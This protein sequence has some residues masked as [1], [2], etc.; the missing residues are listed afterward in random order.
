MAAMKRSA[1][2]LTSLLILSSSSPTP[3]TAQ[4]LALRPQVFAS[5]FSSPV[6]F[7]QDPANRAVQFVVEQGGRIRVVRD[8]VVLPNDFLDL[9]SAI[10]SGGE[11]GLLGMA[12]PADSSGRVFVNFTNPAGHT[13]VARFRRSADPLV[14]D[15]ASRFD[16]RWGGGSAFIVQP[17][18]NH[19][20]G[21]MVF[22]PDGSLYI[23][24]GDGG[25][26][27]DPDH[28]AQNLAELLGKMLR[29]DVSVPDGHPNGYQIP[30]DNPFAAG[31]GRPEIWSVGLRNPWR[32][33]FD[34]P[35]RGGTGAMVLGDV[36]Q[37]RFEE[38]DYEP[39]GRGGRNYGW[40]NREGA[41]DNVTSRP[42]AFTPLVDPVHEYS[43][44]DGQ[45]ITGGFVYRGRLLGAGFVGRYFFAD[46]VQ[47]RVWSIA[48]SPDG[49]SGEA[50]AAGLIEHTADLSAGTAIGSVSAFGVDA[51]GEL[52]VV[53][54]GRGAI[55]KLVGL[56][57][58]SAPATPTGLR[59]IRN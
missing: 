49:S 52:Y 37:G 57:A 10:S 9:R 24:M 16:L 40:R 26:S 55:V 7:L 53:S 13:V 50:R 2:L 31:G 33:S 8:G 42:P 46:F 38:V 19:N 39:P 47:G 6:L 41:H 18:S 14:A 43:R 11:R 22:G 59:I 23:G 29:I 51:D 27:D 56:G 17:F 44:A 28:R 25:A 32:F 48:L 4:T 34:D 58:T 3:G 54:Y 36:G 1:A 21:H 35:G 45:S 5:G 12:I 30:G 20:G 15:P